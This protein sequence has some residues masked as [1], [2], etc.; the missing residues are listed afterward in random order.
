MGKILIIEDH[1]T[2]CQT[3]KILLEKAGYETLT[4]HNGA[5]GIKLA[6]ECLPDLIVCD[7]MMPGMDGYEV[8][9]QL[10]CSGDTSSIPFIFLTARAEMADLRLG[11]ELGADDYL[12]KPFKAN[13]LLNAISKRLEKR[14]LIIKGQMSKIRN[15]QRDS[16][17]KSNSVIAAG[18]PPEIIKVSSIVYITANDGYTHIHST[19][20][21]K[22]LI[23]RLMKEWEALLPE[24]Q[25]IRIHHSTIINLDYMEQIE[26]WF[27][28]SLRIH[29]RT[30]NEPLEV[31]KRYA[32][33]VK[34][35]LIM[36]G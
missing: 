29:M 8:L 21:K 7:I 27:N 19:E 2:V 14:E 4:A 5:D 17:L 22:I 26:K 18:N 35:R 32:P 24:D 33:K 12:V 1:L 16:A 23:R 25:F 10:S 36:K 15:A 34:A 11:M 6:L 28:N 30:I 9:R 3:I 13:E 31:S 20:G